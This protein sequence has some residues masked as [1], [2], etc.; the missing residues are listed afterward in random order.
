MDI[1]YI[2]TAATVAVTAPLSLIVIIEKTTE[3]NLLGPFSNV[4]HYG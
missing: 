3:R 1:A 2:A 4:C